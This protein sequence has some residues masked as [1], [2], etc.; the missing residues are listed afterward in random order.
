M[1]SHLSYVI[2]D[3]SKSERTVMSMVRKWTDETI[4]RFLDDTSLENLAFDEALEDLCER[5]DTELSESDP[6]F[7]KALREVVIRCVEK[8]IASAYHD[9]NDYALDFT[10]KGKK[11]AITGCESWGDLTDEFDDFVLADAAIELTKEIQGDPKWKP[12]PEFELKGLAR[13]LLT[14]AWR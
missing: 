10:H 6:E 12:C 4:D 3:V 5:W 14:A 13:E 7:R 2:V 8:A 11:F 1:G 9:R